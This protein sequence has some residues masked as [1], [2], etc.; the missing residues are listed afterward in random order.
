MVAACASAPG[1][2]RP[3]PLDPAYAARETAA[4]SSGD[5]C[6]PKFISD[7][8]PPSIVSI[9]GPVLD[10]PFYPVCA[11]HDACYGLQEHTQSWC[12]L[13]MR[14]EMMD[15]CAAGRTESAFGERLCRMRAQLYFNM[16]DN[17]FGA[18]AYEG[19]AGGRITSLD[20]KDAP[21]GQFE[22]CVTVHNDTSVVQEYILDLRASDGNRIDRDPDVKERSV[23][24]GEAEILCAGTTGSSY[25]SLKRLT[26]P[27]DVRLLADRPDSIAFTGDLVIVDERQVE[28]DALTLPTN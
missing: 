21:R 23:R 22:L 20:I 1:T 8:L 3:V 7:R 10:G 11:R 28:L 18:Y 2:D 5:R 9:M 13:R 4:I 24:A 6:G 25:W 16:V 27:V 12:D 17:A 19:E 14:T 15:I 26:G